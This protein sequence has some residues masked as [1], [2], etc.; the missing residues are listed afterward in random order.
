MTVPSGGRA[1]GEG[2]RS[3][4]SSTPVELPAVQGLFPPRRSSVVHVPCPLVRLLARHI[5]G[6]TACREAGCCCRQLL[7]PHD[8]AIVEVVRH[9][10]KRPRLHLLSP[11][12]EPPEGG[13]KG[14]TTYPVAKTAAAKTEEHVS[15]GTPRPVRKRRL[16]QRRCTPRPPERIPA[17]VDL[18]SHPTPPAQPPHTPPPP[19]STTSPPSHP[20]PSRHP[21]LPTRTHPPGPRRQC[22]PLPAFRPSWSGCSEE[23]RPHQ[24][25]SRR[26]KEKEQE[27]GI[28]VGM[29]KVGGRRA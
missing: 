21:T 5:L 23:S 28:G 7:P 4:P 16:P 12:G 18:F 6:R 25:H 29:G 13:G 3:P 2:I 27:R 15:D 19:D 24:P 17:V 26:L 9:I 22:R 1:T 10:L 20:R 14:M 11:L 8:R